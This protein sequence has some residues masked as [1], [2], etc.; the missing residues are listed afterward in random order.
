MQ[1]LI[2]MLKEARSVSIASE[3]I[4]QTHTNAIRLA[5]SMLEKEKEQIMIAYNNCELC[6]AEQYYNETFNTA[7]EMTDFTLKEIFILNI[8][9]LL[10]NHKSFA[11][12][13]IIMHPKAYALIFPDELINT[14][15]GIEIE[16]ND[17]APQ[18]YFYIKQK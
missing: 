11:P 10:T 12:D 18:D 15:M 2:E 8:D 7:E 4:T 5:Q 13:R 6:D 16:I 9:Y 14:Y 17:T 1:E 3:D